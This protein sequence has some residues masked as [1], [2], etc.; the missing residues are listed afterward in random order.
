MG[1]PTVRIS[2]LGEKIW[3]TYV[4]G[5]G[6]GPLRNVFVGGSEERCVTRN[7]SYDAVP[8]SRLELI[9]VELGVGNSKSMIMMLQFTALSS[10]W[11]HIS[12]SETT[13]YSPRR[14]V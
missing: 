14:Y 9:V 7:E 12:P 6:E 11:I 1:Q 8:L 3:C 13:S 10:N 2:L 4:E 5:H